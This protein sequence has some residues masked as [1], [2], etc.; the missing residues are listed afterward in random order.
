MLN[1][2]LNNGTMDIVPEN[3]GNVNAFEQAKRDF[4]TAYTS[5][6]DYSPALL[7]LSTAIA[8]SVVRKCLD[9]Q[10]KTAAEH[11][12]VSDNG[13]N[14]AMVE[15]KRGIVFDRRTLD[16]TAAN[17][18]AATHTIY[19]ENGDAVTET[20]DKDAE[21]AVKDLIRKTLSDGIDLVQT[22][23]CALLEQAAEHATVSAG[24]LDRPYTVTR[25]SRRVYIRLS[26]SAAYRDDTTAPIQEVY[27][28]VRRAVQ[29]SRA[30]QTDPRNGY[31]YIESLTSDG[32]DT[33]YFRMQ[34]YADIG[35]Y[36]CNGYDENSLPGA[37][38]GYGKKEVTSRHIGNYTADMQTATDYND[39]I[40]KLNLTAQ[41]REVLELRMKGNGYKAIASY[42]GVTQR[43]IA[44]TVEQIQKK[45]RAIGL[46]PE[47]AEN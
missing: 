2:K 27:R 6:G 39:I 19:N 46:N 10:R 28:A 3:S 1:A 18:N 29:E 21:K 11:D 33:I 9:P 32:L 16:N 44:K 22:A 25:L 30:V 41:Q 31:T 8:H 13:Q 4:E 26:D 47:S 17:A 43:A 36:A 45:A 5:G 14:P 35:G 34:K 24:W 7:T 40:I 38:A 23:A 15:L 20:A 42:L 12:T 37:P